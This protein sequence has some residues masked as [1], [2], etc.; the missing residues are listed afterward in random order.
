MNISNVGTHQRRLICWSFWQKIKIFGTNGCHVVDSRIKRLPASSF[1][2]WSW[3]PTILFKHKTWQLVKLMWT[4][5]S[6]DKRLGLSSPVIGEIGEP[7]VIPHLQVSWF[8]LDVGPGRSTREL[9][10][11]GLRLLAGW[12]SRS[13]WG[14]G[15]RATPDERRLGVLLQM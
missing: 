7:A 1:S 3:G 4:D 10:I 2:F 15:P 13:A 12:A 11:E 8:S 14:G 5:T 6:E 9:S